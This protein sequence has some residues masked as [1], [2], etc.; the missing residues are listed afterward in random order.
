M[1]EDEKTM[2][3]A[4]LI[5]HLRVFEPTLSVYTEGCDCTGDVLGVL[6]WNGG[7]L[8]SRNKEGISDGE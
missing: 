8:I 1:T 6:A 7:V 3:V 4:E 2:T 5:E